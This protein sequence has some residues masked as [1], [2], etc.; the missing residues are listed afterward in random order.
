MNINLIVIKQE[1]VGSF[2]PDFPWQKV[3]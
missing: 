2:Y 1:E 3:N